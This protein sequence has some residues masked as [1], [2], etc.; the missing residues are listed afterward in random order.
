MGY[1]R[2][3]LKKTVFRTSEENPLPLLPLSEVIRLKKE[4]KLPER[5]A[6]YVDDMAL[7][8]DL[9]NKERENGN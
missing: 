6:W 7:Y 8:L 5:F 1:L 3:E 2:D 9:F 4:G